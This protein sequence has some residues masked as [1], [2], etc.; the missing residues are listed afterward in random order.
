M[1]L[2]YSIQEL[3]TSSENHSIIFSVFKRLPAGNRSRKKQNA[4]NKRKRAESHDERSLPGSR[5]NT[6]NRVEWFPE[7]VF[8]SWI[9]YHRLIYSYSILFRTFRP[10][11]NSIQIFW[12]VFD[13]PSGGPM[14]S[15][16]VLSGVR[17]CRNSLYLSLPSLLEE[18]MLQIGLFW[19][20]GWS[21]FTENCVQK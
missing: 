9:E 12:I 11:F 6:E 15:K 18:S 5:L 4:R 19:G 21:F 10:V 8:N 7:E 2:W 3:N 16:R 1:S 13:R 14:A 17:R 20:I